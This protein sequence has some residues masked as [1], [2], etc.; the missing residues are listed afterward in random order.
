MLPRFHRSV[1]SAANTIYYESCM[2]TPGFSRGF[3]YSSA[4]PQDKT[5]SVCMSFVVLMMSKPCFVTSTCAHFQSVS[6][7]QG[8]MF[9]KM[10]L[11]C[12]SAKT[13]G[14]CGAFELLQQLLLLYFPV[15]CGKPPKDLP[16]FT[17][18]L[19]CSPACAHLPFPTTLLRACSC[20]FRSSVLWS[21]S[22]SPTRQTRFTLLDRCFDQCF[23]RFGLPPGRKSSRPLNNR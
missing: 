21:L 7:R 15:V 10:R 22:G 12:V 4:L 9:R 23:G 14:I 20:R 8:N 6:T 13:L 5:S 1:R 16:G 18:P 11:C 17:R 3:T 19:F 2:K